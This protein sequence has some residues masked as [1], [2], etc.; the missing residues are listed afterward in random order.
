MAALS[1]ASILS[2]TLEGVSRVEPGN[3]EY[4]ELFPY[5]AHPNTEQAIAAPPAFGQRNDPFANAFVDDSISALSSK[6]DDVGLM[7]LLL[8]LG[9]NPYDVLG[10]GSDFGGAPSVDFVPLAG[11]TKSS[12]KATIFNSPIRRRE[13]MGNVATGAA[14]FG[15]LGVL[16]NDKQNSD[17]REAQAAQH[18]MGDLEHAWNEAN[19][20]VR[21]FRGQKPAEFYRTDPD[22]SKTAQDYL[23]PNPPPVQPFNGTDSSEGPDFGWQPRKVSPFTAAR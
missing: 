6:S 16:L 2:P 21:G 4:T 3:G 12:G 20:Q 8:S 14:L 19:K 13:V 17:S 10:G 18:Q 11:L 23:V 5:G 15:G 7:Y 1:L 22:T 9:L